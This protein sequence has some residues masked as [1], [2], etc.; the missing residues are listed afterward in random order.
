MHNDAVRTAAA[1]QETTMRIA[2]LVALGT[3]LLSQPAL[4]QTAGSYP[5]RPVTV[6]VPMS[7][8]GTADIVTRA[9]APGVSAALGQS[10]V[11]ENRI[12][13]N[14]SIGEEYV[15]RAKPDGYTVMLTSTS[16]V[17]NPW[18]AQ[19]SYDPRK[20]FI[21]V[22]LIT[23]VPLVLAVHPDV[24]VSTAREFV[25][26]AQRRNG[27]LNYSSWGNGSI[28]HFAGEN[29]QLTAN[30]KMK[31]VP[32]KST[33]QA[34]N[35]VLGGQVDAMFPT[36][37]L[38]LQHIKAGKLRA[39]ALTSPAR[40]PLAPEIPTMAEAGY[41][42]NEVETWFGVFLPTGTDPAIVKRVHGAFHTVLTNPEMKT[43]LEGMGFRIIAS[44]PEEFARFLN[45]QLELYGS[46]VKK[47]N[48]KGL[49]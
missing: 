36:L 12:G 6:V 21:P 45:T 1:Q 20:A 7:A 30:Y 43:R 4:S 49:E 14:G 5:S 46:L 25:D 22:M 19:L 26:L 41:P 32:Y 15:S 2:T 34:L 47:A 27:G 48:L 37:P 24:K 11:I 3:A 29:M 38:A 23:S 13:A 10:V 44:E 8:G 42:G 28:G 18:M 16:V 39:L 17:T 33:A 31:H 40:S 9:I 35:D